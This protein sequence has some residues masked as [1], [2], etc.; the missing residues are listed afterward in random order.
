MGNNT[1]KTSSKN[2]ELRHY[3]THDSNNRI[4]SQFTG[5]NTDL[6]KYKTQFDEM[7]GF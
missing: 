4:L 5:K 3:E 1:T 6:L 2:T 7:R